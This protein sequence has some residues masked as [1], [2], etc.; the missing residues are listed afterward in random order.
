MKGPRSYTR[1]DVVEIQMH[2]GS[3]VL[4][5]VI[6]MCIA[7]GARLAEAGEFTRRAFMNGRIDLTEAE[8]VMRM[9]TA[10]SSQEHKAAVRQMN[11]GAVAY[12]RKA[13]DQ[14]YALQA[15]LAA[16][17]DYPEEISDREGTEALR[18]GILQLIGKAN[19]PAP[20]GPVRDHDGLPGH[21]SDDLSDGAG[22][23]IRTSSAIAEDFLFL[24]FHNHLFKHIGFDMFSHIFIKYR[25]R[26]LVLSFKVAICDFN[27]KT[28]CV[29]RKP[30]FA[31]L[32]SLLYQPVFYFNST[33][34][35]PNVIP[36]FSSKNLTMASPSRRTINSLQRA[37]AFALAPFNAS[38]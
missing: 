28:A 32:Q 9:I 35:M 34:K 13:A 27:Q 17:I 15:G 19:G 38:A 10:R 7:R 2:A 24:Q 12:T 3:Y 37:M 4:Q 22:I 23:D 33:G 16:C 5:R 21:L 1:E 25:P 29:F 20:A 6:E 8:A 14:L 11:G 36:P 30:C 26:L 18:P 31:N